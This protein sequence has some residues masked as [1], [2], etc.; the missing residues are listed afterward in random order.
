M[1]RALSQLR[2]WAVTVLFNDGGLH[3]TWPTARNMLAMGKSLQVYGNGPGSKVLVHTWGSEF[4]PQNLHLK[5][6][7]GYGTM[8]LQSQCWGSEWGLRQIHETHLVRQIRLLSG[9]QANER[10]SLIKN[11]GT[12]YP[13]NNTG[14]QESAHIFIHV[15]QHT[16]Y[17]VFAVNCFNVAFFDLSIG[18]QWTQIWKDVLSTFLWASLVVYYIQL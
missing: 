9:P 8:H 17:G 18:C 11:K 3:F 6:N 4:H 12:W 15:P 16:I 13:R 2:W 1:W 14:T 10:L 7:P 5:R